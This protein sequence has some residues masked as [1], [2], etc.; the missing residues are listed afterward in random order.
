MTDKPTTSLMGFGAVAVAVLLVTGYLGWQAYNSPAD[1]A[2]AELAATQATE[3]VVRAGGGDAGA[4]S[5]MQVLTASGAAEGVVERCT[6]LASA[7]TANGMRWLG[8]R[9]LHVI[10]SDLG[11]G[12]GTVTVTGTL[13]TPAA[14]YPMTF[15]WP[16]TREDDQWKVSGGADVDVQ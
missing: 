11:R 14:S 3:V 2:G 5:T 12:S 8:A 9:D 7:A 1:P 13:L 10:E 15:T 6:Q 4:C 16:V